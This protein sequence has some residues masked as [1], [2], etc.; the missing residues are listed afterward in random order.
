MTE[1]YEKSL[2][3]L[4]LGQVLRCFPNAREARAARRPAW[5]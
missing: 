2:S 5:R 1:L 3:K 4:E